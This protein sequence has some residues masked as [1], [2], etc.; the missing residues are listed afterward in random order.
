[1]TETH[2]VLARKYR[3][4]QFKDVIHQD[5]PIN[6]LQN[7]LKHNRIGHA[8]IFF[9]PRGVGKTTIARI[10]AKR[11]N[12][13]NP[14][15]NEPCN[16]C[17]SCVEITK[18][19]SNDVIEIDAASNRGID[20]IRDL[21]ESVKFNAM[22]GKYRIYI[23]DEV[24]MLS[25]PAFNALLKTLEEPPHHVVFVLA[26]TDFHKVPETILS[27]CQ[28]FVFK[29]VPTVILQDY[30]EK[31]CKIESLKYDEEGLFWIA[32]KGDGSVRDTLSFMEQAVTFTDKNLTGPS[33]IKMVGYQGIDSQVD[34]FNSILEDNNPKKAIS[35]IEKL[36]VEGS[37]L[38]RFLWGF[39]EFTH[40]AVLIK[41]NLVDRESINYPKED[42]LKIQKVT[43]NIGPDIIVTLTEKIYQIYEKLT[44][45]RL[46]NSFEMK[47]FL[48][49]NIQKLIMEINKPSLS[50]LLEKINDLTE[51]VQ[52]DIK[53]MPES[54]ESTPSTSSE[55]KEEPKITETPVEE[56]ESTLKD[57]F[58][59]VEVDSKNLP[60]IS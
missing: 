42:I 40:S 55:K 38:S 4:Q 41:E 22:G 18:G 30:I 47:V 51:L 1:M 26:T 33:I 48:E 50:G 28:D 10:L 17:N 16:K 54:A 19:V 44:L 56:I 5:I 23:I 25:L 39:L 9:G 52:S 14:T 31:L 11:L 60:D 27:R 32:K 7:A 13:E 59:G 36:Y 53:A 3:P 58:S 21:R 2:L 8:Y 37:D 12:C 20:D 45:L 24:H 35:I 15:E 29:K 46:R 6:A 49:I 34:F 57:R 43:E